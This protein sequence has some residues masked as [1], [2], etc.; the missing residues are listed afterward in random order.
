[1]GERGKGSQVSGERSEWVLR[2]QSLL[3]CAF[4]SYFCVD[5]YRILMG[6]SVQDPLHGAPYFSFYRPRESVGYSG[7]KREER[8]R[9][10]PPRSLGPSSPS[11][12]SRQPCRYQQGRL[13]VAVLSVT[14]AMSRRHPSVIALHSV[15]VDVVLN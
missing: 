8:E 12:G 2:A 10:R 15:L 5:L 7:G 6:R 11:Y 1:M 3:S 4:M 13:H 9:G 14:G